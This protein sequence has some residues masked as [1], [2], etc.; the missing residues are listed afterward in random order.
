MVLTSCSTVD[1]KPIQQ[2]VVPDLNP[3][4]AIVTPQ[5][6]KVKSRSEPEVIVVNI[7][8][9]WKLSWEI[10][11]DNTNMPQVGLAFDVEKCDNIENPI[12]TLYYQTNQPSVPFSFINNKG[13]F[14][15]GAHLVTPPTP[16]PFGP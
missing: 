8:P 2:N 5:S 7:L 6:F 13:F 3:A 11:G 9:P 10:G 14:R 4:H 15:V 1:K 16:A 12:W